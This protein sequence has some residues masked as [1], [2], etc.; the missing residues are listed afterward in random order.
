MIGNQTTIKFS[1]SGNSFFTN[2]SLNLLPYRFNI[3]YGRNGSGKSSISRSIAA[4]VSDLSIES[5]NIEFDNPL[6]DEDKKHVFVFNE[7]YIEKN[8][9]VEQDG[10]A[11]II[12]LG[13][14]VELD[15]AI[16]ESEKRLSKINAEKIDLE[17][18]LNKD[19]P[20][21]IS[22]KY[23]QIQD[24]LIESLKK[25]ECWADR[26]S[27]IKGKKIYTKVN[28]VTLNDIILSGKGTKT[29]ADLSME[30]QEGIVKI[31]Q[32]QGQQP[33]QWICP[34][35]PS[36]ID[37]KTVNALLSITKEV[38]EL[39][40]REKNILQMVQ[41]KYGHYIS[42]SEKIFLDNNVD[43]CPLCLRP[44]DNVGKESVIQ[45]V[46]RILNEDAQKYKMQLDNEKSKFIE[47][48]KTNIPNIENSYFS[49][50]IKDVTKSIRVYNSEINKANT[51]IQERLENIYQ[52]YSKIIDEDSFNKSLTDLSESINKLDTLIKDFN[53]V[54][55]EQET[56]KR[57]L[58]QINKH[59]AYYELEALINKYTVL[60]NDT[61][62]LTQELN[63]KKEEEQQELTNLNSL[64]A[65]K[66]QVTIALSFI[67]QALSYV[68][69][70]KNRMQLTKQAG[71][72]TLLSRE[73]DVKPTK[74]SVGER[75]II[76]LCYFF[77]SMFV[78]KKDKDK[79][80]D[81][82]IIIIDD[83]VSSFDFENRVG[84]ISLLRWMSEQFIQGNPNTKILIMTHDIQTV[85][86]LQ[87]IRMEL[88]ND[89]RKC[90][91]LEL[92]DKKI[93]LHKNGN[94]NEYK[95][96]IVSVYDF[97]CKRNVDQKMAVIG[98]QMRKL[99]EAY[100]SFVYA[101]DFESISH[102]NDVIKN[103]P[104]NKRLYYQNLMT[105]LVLNGESHEQEAAKAM[106]LTGFKFTKD[107]KV[108]I[109][110]SIIMFLY[111]INPKHVLAYL[112]EEGDV[113]N[114]WANDGFD[115]L[116]IS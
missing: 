105:R 88:E 73:K 78:G 42:D 11:P 26:D 81:A 15:D 103:I 30:V 80:K 43:V 72:Y 6:D 89:R 1:N 59:L 2:E 58:I 87:K 20:E 25:E 101:H 38:P 75:N 114:Q 61:A 35:L 16:K 12:M 8:I 39:S 77:A 17:N 71:I 24:K 10:L 29:F 68:F 21:S 40:E 115:V 3:L 52:P 13:E 33:I 102:D 95:N 54:I 98:N 94:L 45:I 84:V 90:E 110:K 14:Q 65:Q 109:A 62:N 47:F 27:K 93:D 53:N 28:E 66:Q 32:S 116:S 96:I 82:S 7:G 83:P 4:Y 107:E 23:Y 31:G 60:K 57:S 85:F 99:M 69:F 22:N 113:L 49:N 18:K 100:C 76:A 106:D 92:I 37:I 44:I 36:S 56:F 55:N 74:I 111:Y 64:K 34:N 5:P 51:I 91:F 19:I 9:K 112:P 46:K 108:N 97:A 67:N 70:D 104:E 50:A 63:K 41:G 86:N 48:P 79:Y